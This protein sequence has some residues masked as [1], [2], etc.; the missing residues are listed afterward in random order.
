MQAKMQVKNFEF[1]ERRTNYVNN[2]TYL[3]GDRYDVKKEVGYSFLKVT[4][5]KESSKLSK[6][7][8]EGDETAF[9]RLQ[10]ELQKNGKKGKSFFE[11]NS[12]KIVYTL[13]SVHLIFETI[14]ENKTNTQNVTLI[15]FTSNFNH[16][17]GLTS[18]TYKNRKGHLENTRVTKWSDF[19]YDY[20][21]ETY[22]ANL[23]YIRISLDNRNYHIDYEFY[24]GNIRVSFVDNGIVKFSYFTNQNAIVAGQFMSEKE[25]NGKFITDELKTLPRL[26]NLTVEKTIS[27][28]ING[29]KLI[30]VVI[31]NGVLI[32]LDIYKPNG[33][34]ERTLKFLNGK[35]TE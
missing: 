31:E 30:Q 12:V 26:G 11:E 19:K 4:A 22:G 1:I 16:F 27:N 10:S 14:N 5:E 35:I 6:I 15:P 2:Y 3:Y 7:E 17:D 34:K 24:E 18:L 8:L 33:E 32:K 9:S 29:N 28:F 21:N 23:E 20:V 25:V 13:N